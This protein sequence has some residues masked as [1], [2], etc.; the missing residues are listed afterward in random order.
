MLHQA[1][2][3]SLVR[4]GGWP[5]RRDAEPGPPTAWHGYPLASSR[6]LI[7]RIG[8]IG[9]FIGYIMATMDGLIRSE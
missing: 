3:F 8:R 6:Y 1:V 9:T 5:V 4:P 7:G 2:L